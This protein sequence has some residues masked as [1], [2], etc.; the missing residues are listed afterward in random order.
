[1]RKLETANCEYFEDPVKGDLT[2][3]DD[4][5]GLDNLNLALKIRLAI[6]QLCWT[7]LVIRRSA[8]TRR[9]NIHIFED[10]SIASGFR[11]SLVREP[12]PVQ[13]W[14]KKSARSISCE[15]TSRAVRAVRAGSKSH[16][17]HTRLRVA[18]PGDRFAPVFVIFIGFT[19]YKRNFFTPFHKA[20]TFTALDDFLVE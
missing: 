3:T 9:G 14:E 6:I 17:E 11:L 19:F 15:L 10:E 16:H 5:F 12:G 20:R 1:M 2:Q 7:G 13:R 8:A 18:K 4:D